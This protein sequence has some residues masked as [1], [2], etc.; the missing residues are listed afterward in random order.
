M[1]IVVAFLTFCSLL[2]AQEFYSKIFPIDTF[3]VK[4]SVIGKV[5][6]V[7]SN[8]ENS[9]IKNKQI[10][11]I[12]DY[13]DRIDYKESQ[14]K[15]QN[16]SEILKIQK[17]TYE[18]YTKVSSK[19]KLE[20]DTQFIQVLN[21]ETSLSDLKIKLATLK[22]TLDNKNIVVENKY[23]ASIN[24]QVGDYVNPGTL[25]YTAYDLSKGKLEIFLPINE[26]ENYK[27]KAI[28]IDGNKSDLKLHS[29]SK[30]ADLVHISSYKAEIIIENPISFSKLVK[31]EFK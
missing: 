3:Q 16:L 18:S 1:K 12:D 5:L 14:N 8:L 26:I 24:V 13:V 22:N 4:S 27:N 30:V 10:I 11:K 2:I 9:F 20:R 15:L 17:E 23:L 21:T 19:S 31:I 7:K 29:I 25:L 6:S 28:Y